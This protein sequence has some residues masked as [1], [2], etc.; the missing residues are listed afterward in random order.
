[1]RLRRLPFRGAN[2]EEIPSRD[3]GSIPLGDKAATPDWTR[4]SV[5]HRHPDDLSYNICHPTGK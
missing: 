1:M 5:H 2:V 3:S 4:L